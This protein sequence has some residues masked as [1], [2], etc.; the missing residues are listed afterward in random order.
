MEKSVYLAGPIA[1]VSYKDCNDWR[2]YAKKE[3]AKYNILGVSP[4]RHKG[5]FDPKQI[6]K[7]VGGGNVMTTGRGIITRDRYDTTHC[8]AIL[9]NLFGA[10]KISIGTMFEYAWADIMRIPIITIME[11]KGNVH[12]HNFVREVSGFRLNNLEEGILVARNLLCA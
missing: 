6:M 4:T 5:N 8:N 2:E 10:K 7:D 12:D 3:L 9:A 11:D 1:E